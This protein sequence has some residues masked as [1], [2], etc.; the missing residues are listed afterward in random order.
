VQQRAPS[1]LDLALTATDSPTEV[2]ATMTVQSATEAGATPK[3][4]VV[5][6]VDVTKLRFDTKQERRT[7]KLTFLAAFLDTT[8]VCVTG[9]QGELDLALKPET[10]DRLAREGGMNV[11][12]P[13]QPPA[14]NYTLRGIVIEGLDGK[15]TAASQALALQ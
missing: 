2:P 9:I 1:K 6:N 8:G 4:V 14:G 12:L 10:Y 11:R 15:I 3:I 5:I 13:L 7:Q